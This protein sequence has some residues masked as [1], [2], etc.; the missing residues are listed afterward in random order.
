MDRKNYYKNY[1]FEIKKKIVLSGESKIFKAW[2]E[3]LPNLTEEMFLKELK[4]LCEDEAHEGEPLTRELGL[5]GHGLV[6]LKRAKEKGLNVFRY[7]DGKL[8]NGDSFYR[9]CL[10]P[11]YADENGMIWE[12]HKISISARDRI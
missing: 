3:V 5:T 1:S 11:N 4:W 10:D 7:P 9:P 6:R 12:R 2:Q 8:W